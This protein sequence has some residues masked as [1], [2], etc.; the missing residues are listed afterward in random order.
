MS[1][2]KFKAIEPMIPKVRKSQ[3]VDEEK[4]IKVLVSLIGEELYAFDVM[5]VKR[6][7]E[8]E[9]QKNIT[10]DESSIVGTVDI[11]GQIIPTFNICSKIQAPEDT[12]L[13][14]LIVVEEFD[15]LW[16]I[17]VTE[18]ERLIEIGVGSIDYNASKRQIVDGVARYSDTL[19]SI[20]AFDWLVAEV[21]SAHD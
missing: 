8:T 18:A 1:G 17:W 3:E 2:E 16:G 7:T 12:L 21:E 6:I 20:L 4:K 9:Y 11:D 10:D 14:K 15:S 19:I 13:Q 5:K